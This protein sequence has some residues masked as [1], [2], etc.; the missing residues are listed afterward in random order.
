M[1]NLSTLQLDLYI[2]SKVCFVN[3]ERIELKLQ[4]ELKDPNIS[5]ERK[6]IIK[7]DLS[8]IPHI[9][10]SLKDLEIMCSFYACQ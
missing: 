9:S 2:N 4:A 1:T 8:R 3:L 6:Q 7:R 10:K 5:E